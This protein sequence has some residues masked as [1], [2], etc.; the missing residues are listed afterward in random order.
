[1]SP[2]ITA[3]LPI[4]GKPKTTGKRIISPMFSM[5]R[6]QRPRNGA[7]L[8]HCNH[9]NEDIYWKPGRGC[10]PNPWPHTNKLMKTKAKTTEKAVIEK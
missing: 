6:G 4:R 9:N 2:M 1:M 8:I 3:G 10:T 5:G 7:V